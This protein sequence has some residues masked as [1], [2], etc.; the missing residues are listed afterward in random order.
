MR[1]AWVATDWE[2]D[3]YFLTAG[4]NILIYSQCQYFLKPT[5]VQ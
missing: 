3:M 2:E 1:M 5:D 4:L